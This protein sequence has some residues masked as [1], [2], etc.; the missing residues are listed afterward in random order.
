MSGAVKLSCRVLKALGYVIQGDRLLVFRQVGRPEQGVQVPGGSVEPGEAPADAVLR[1]VREETGL[2]D[3]RVRRFLG[4]RHYELKVDRGPPH[5]RHFFELTCDGAVAEQW[6]HPG[7]LDAALRPILFDF[8]W[9]PLA[10]VRLD[11]EMDVYLSALL[12]LQSNC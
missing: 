6:Q 3:V 12:D 2:T 8:W 11:W 9:E 4:S 5:L 1:E 7:S 10:T